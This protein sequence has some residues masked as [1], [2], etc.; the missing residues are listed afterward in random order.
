MRGLVRRADRATPADGAIALLEGLGARSGVRVVRRAG[1][2]ALGDDP[3]AAG[4]FFFGGI[5][6]P[7]DD[8]SFSEDSVAN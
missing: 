1:I 4:E 7:G 2:D 3:P 8:P 6:V 5:P